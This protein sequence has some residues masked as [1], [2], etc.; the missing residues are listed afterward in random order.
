MVQ[1]TAAE[2]GQRYGVVTRIAGQL[3]IGPE[4]LRE[5]VRQAEVDRG[6]RG[7]PGASW[8]TEGVRPCLDPAGAGLTDPV[9]RI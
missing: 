1:E 2:D 4:S 5:W 6:L 3:G 9:E 8:P 7:P